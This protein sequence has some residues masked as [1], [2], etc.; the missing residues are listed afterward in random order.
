MSTPPRKAAAKAAP[1]PGRKRG[2]L[3]GGSS[4]PAKA[5][6]KDQTD[7]AKA[8]KPSRARARQAV[9][10]GPIH[11]THVHHTHASHD[12]HE[13][14]KHEGERTDPKAAGKASSAASARAAKQALLFGDG[15]K[16]KRGKGF[17]WLIAAVAVALVAAVV[18]FFAADFELDWSRVT[19]FWARVTQFIASLEPAFVLPLMALLPVVGFPISV[20]Y[21][22]A[23]ARFGPVWGGVVVAG[24][25]AVHLALSHAVA[26]RFFRGP[27]T[28]FVERKGKHL[29][30]IPKDEHAAVAV[31]GS[32]A[33]G[34][35]YVLRNYML[36]ISGIPLRTYFWIC[37]PIYVARSYVT[38]LLGDLSSAP[39][40]GR[41][42]ILLIVDVIKIGVCAG[43]IWW[44]RVHHRKTHP[45]T[46]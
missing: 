5:A 12:K 30:N 34:L 2:A 25:T 37:L 44:L 17:W 22:V 9:D 36:A 41:L 40:G 14:V 13:G 33:P 26:T 27:I 3:A 10:S 1:G 4:S 35:P 8:A 29:P 15:E 39:S 38:I 11:N 24:V 20:V 45:K 19:N 43:V 32:L 7:Q 23:G 21:L 42:V 31:V 16:K 6:D 28:R 18:I 46:V